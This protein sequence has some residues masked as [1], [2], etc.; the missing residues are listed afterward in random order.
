MVTIKSISDVITNSSNETYL[1]K[2]NLTTKGY[3][4]TMEDILR[5]YSRGLERDEMI[6]IILEV[7]GLSIT[8]NPCPPSKIN[9]RPWDNLPIDPDYDELWELFVKENLGSFESLCDYKIVRG[10][11]DHD[12]DWDEWNSI[13]EEYRSIST[14]SA[15]RDCWLVNTWDLEDLGEKYDNHQIGF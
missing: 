2:N 3:Q 7:F 11:Y 4:I 15:G 9:Y 1:I 13:C 8:N 5:G 10:P 12:Y 6:Y 14:L